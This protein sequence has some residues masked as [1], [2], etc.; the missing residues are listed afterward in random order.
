MGTIFINYRRDDSQGASFSLQNFLGK[1]FGKR[2][3]FLDIHGL[4]AGAEF[5]IQLEKQVAACS[6]MIVMIGPYWL[7]TVDDGSR[8]IDNPD[9]FVRIEIAKAL[10][11]RKPILPVLVGEAKMPAPEELPE[12]IRDLHRFNGRPLRFERFDA[13]A[14]EIAAALRN[15]IKRPGLSPWWL[16]AA[17]AAGFAVA[18]PLTPWALQWAPNESWWPNWVRLQISEL[19]DDVREEKDRTARFDTRISELTDQRNEARSQRDAALI[20]AK[21]AIH[22]FN[23]GV[24]CHV[25][26]PEQRGEKDR[27]SSRGT[28]GEA[29]RMP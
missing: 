19:R 22:L 21:R 24:S 17:A 10:S 20:D 5:D 29:F 18:A 16:G 13:D 25:S 3:I 28:S 1:Q 7:K 6:A 27:L 12:V 11:L 26:V 4:D 14:E 2:R 9:D 8:R 23:E 15:M